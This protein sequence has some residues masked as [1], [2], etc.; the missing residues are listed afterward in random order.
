MEAHDLALLLRAGSLRAPVEIIEERT[1]GPSLGSDNIN[2]GYKSVVIGF[3]L[4]LVF[5]A[6][7]YKIFGIIADIALT[8]KPG[9]YGCTAVYVAGDINF[10]GY[11]RYC[12]NPWYGGGCKCTYL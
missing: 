10:T 5:M 9:D 12:T 3:V 4:V 7:Y 6:V 11:C 1:I 8:L 2:K